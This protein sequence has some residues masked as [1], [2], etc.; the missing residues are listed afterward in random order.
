MEAVKILAQLNNEKKSEFYQTFESLSSLV[1]KY[2]EEIKIEMD[3][4]N[5]LRITILFSD[6]DELE[7]NFYN[8]EFTILKG[9][10]RSLCNNVRIEINNT[11]LS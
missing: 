5:E 10:V 9:T 1:K 3:S 7:D 11:M 4:D 2:C 6:K 8:N